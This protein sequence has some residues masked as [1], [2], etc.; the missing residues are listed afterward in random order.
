MEAPGPLSLS[1]PIG[2]ESTPLLRDNNGRR[3]TG[4]NNSNSNNVALLITR[5]TMREPSMAVRETAALQLEERQT[6]W[7]YSKPVVVLDMIWN[8]AFVVVSFVVLLSSRR[9]R[10]GTPLRVWI[11][12][13]VIQCVFHV[14]FV[15][16]E[17]RRRN[18]REL[19]RS[20]CIG[21][22]AEDEACITGQIPENQ[23]SNGIVKRLESMNTLASFIWWIIGFYWV[24][25]GGQ[26]L[27]QD[28]PRLYWMAVMFLAFD[29][30]FAILCAALACLI[31]IALCCCLPCIIG[32]LYAVAGQAGASD[33]DISLLPTFTFNRRSLSP[34]DSCCICLSSYEEGAELHSLPCHH[35][36]HSGCIRRWLRINAT[37]P[38]CKFNILKGDENV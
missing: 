15:W 28:A 34:Q 12:G 25:K 9:E 35:C 7:G 26:A 23:M 27:L 20:A 31:G 24:F 32:F 19:G 21:S 3:R 5:A 1:S 29:V 2:L 13:Y 8:M 4:N 18:Y 17:Y 36:F 16:F 10:P 30:F 14:G 38:L 11:V 22:D 6:D 33:A 37:C